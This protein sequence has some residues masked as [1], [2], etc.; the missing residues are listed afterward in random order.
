MSKR[1]DSVELGRGIEPES[2]WIHSQRRKI[3]QRLFEKLVRTHTNLVLRESLDDTL[4]HLLLW[5]IDLLMGV[6]GEKSEP[7]FLNKFLQVA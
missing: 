7:Q 5:D 4:H 1:R 3:N 2:E 6:I